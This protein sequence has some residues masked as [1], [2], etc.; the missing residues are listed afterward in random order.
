M[1]RLF[2]GVWAPE[3]WRASVGEFGRR[4]KRGLSSTLGFVSPE[5][6]HV[7]LAFLGSVS[8]AELLGIKSALGTIRFSPFLLGVSGGGIF[9]ARSPRVLYAR[10]DPGGEALGA[11][12][13][14]VWEA[15]SPLGFTPDRREF[16]PHMTLARIRRALSGDD[17]GRVVDSVGDLSWPSSTVVGASLVASVLDQS[18]SRYNEQLFIPAIVQN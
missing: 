6:A 13:T 3:S 8:E 10:L 1:I 5:K 16:R 7:T 14:Q 2:V 12:S 11:L 17:W 9:G 15:L 18:G 4:W